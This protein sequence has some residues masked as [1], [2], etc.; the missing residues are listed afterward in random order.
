MVFNITTALTVGKQVFPGIKLI[1]S[2]I[3]NIANGF[4]YFIYLPIKLAGYS[5]SPVLAQVIY[6]GLI[7]W[8]INKF[9]KN[10]AYTLLIV[11]ILLV[12]GALA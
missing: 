4:S 1:I 5:P 9:V 11:V 12:L 6:I 3:K 2:G 8:V 7:A 10:W